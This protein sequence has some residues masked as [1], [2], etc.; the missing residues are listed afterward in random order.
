MAH[1]QSIVAY[2]GTDFWGFQ[3]Q[4]TGRRT[5][6][7]VLEAALSALGWTDS[8]LTAA[9]RTD[10]G[11]HARGQVVAYAVVWQRGPEALTQAINAH[12][13]GDVAIRE[14]SLAPDGFHPRFSARS[15]RYSYTVLA[16]PTPDPTRERYGWRIWPKPDLGEMQAGADCLVGRHDFGA[17]GSAPV[18]G[19]H[20]VRMVS[21]ARWRR[22][23]SAWIFEIEA[24]AFLYR[25]VRRLVAAMV[26]I[27]LGAREISQL[28]AALV[29]PGHKWVSRLAPPRGLCL[30]QVNY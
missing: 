18:R 30:E 2:D 21:E 16:A 5:V 27:G 13:P 15:R 19:G 9:G 24:D 3:R 22:E 11:V 17:F 8:S 7:Q 29:D 14:T 1:Y 4:A 12:L 28:H 26:G 23:G 25:M 10:A 6:Q 20:T